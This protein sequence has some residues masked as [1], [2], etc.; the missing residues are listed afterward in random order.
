MHG[1]NEFAKGHASRAI[2]R[3]AQNRIGIVTSYDPASGMAKVEYQPE[4]VLSN[5]LQRVSPMVGNGW[6]LHAP[7]PIGAMVLVAPIEGDGDAGVIIGTLFSDR[8]TPPG[9]ADGEVTLRS[10]TGAVIQLLAGGKAIFKDASGSELNFS[11]DGD[12]KL[13]ATGTFAVQCA[14]FN[15]QATAGVTITTPMTTISNELDVGTG[16][17]KQAGTTVVVP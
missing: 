14:T 15:V 17:I 10:K 5:W 13:T 12:A 9:A 7:L 8:A 6:G 1:L 11:G 2:G 16:P 4:G 3:I